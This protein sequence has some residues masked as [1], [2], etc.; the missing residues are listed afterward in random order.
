MRCN[1]DFVGILA[2]SRIRLVGNFYFNAINY[3]AK[4]F[5]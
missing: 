5:H 4:A 2:L 3:D 1:N